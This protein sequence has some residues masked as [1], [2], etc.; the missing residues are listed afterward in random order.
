MELI[1]IQGAAPG[2]IIA[3]VS[4]RTQVRQIPM[5]VLRHPAGGWHVEQADGDFGPRC[6]AASTAILLQASE[7][8]IE[9]AVFEDSA[10]R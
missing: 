6:H 9:D 8:F 7:A 1:C 4:H 2:H 3:T 10:A 5:T